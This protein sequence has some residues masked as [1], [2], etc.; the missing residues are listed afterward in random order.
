MC[1]RRQ[2]QGH[3]LA[4]V[5]YFIPVMKVAKEVITAW[6]L[7]TDSRETPEQAS[8]D[9]EGVLWSLRFARVDI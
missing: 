7:E 8:P 9:L 6:S 3:K 2:P 1:W 5:S 4:S